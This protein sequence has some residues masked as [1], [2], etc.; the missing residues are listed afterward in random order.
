M[1]WVAGQASTAHGKR[2]P[3]GYDDN[4]GGRLGKAGDDQHQQRPT[5]AVGSME[6][7]GSM[8]GALG[9]GGGDGGPRRTEGGRCDGGAGGD[10]VVLLLQVPRQVRVRVTADVEGAPWALL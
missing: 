7:P 10:G 1:R 8:A 3:E 2:G 6:G 9:G 5:E 4:P